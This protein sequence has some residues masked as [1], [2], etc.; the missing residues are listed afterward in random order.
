MVI[1]HHAVNEIDVILLT[2]LRNVNRSPVASR[3]FHLTYDTAAILAMVHRS[4]SATRVL[5]RSPSD[6][7]DCCSAIEIFRLRTMSFHGLSADII[8]FRQ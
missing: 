8:G 6:H 4:F 7:V 3:P 5:V 2:L 1:V